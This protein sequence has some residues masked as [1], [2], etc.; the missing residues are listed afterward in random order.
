MDGK[1]GYPL[2]PVQS[3]TEFFSNPEIYGKTKMTG[4]I[5]DAIKYSKLAVVPE[6]Y[7]SSFKFIIPQEKDIVR[8]FLALKEKHFDFEKKYSYEFVCRDLHQLL[9]AII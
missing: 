6:D 2:V 5:G 9:H 3:E 8:Q 4:N 7:Y 1:G